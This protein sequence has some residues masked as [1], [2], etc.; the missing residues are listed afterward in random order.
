MIN[1]DLGRSR[2]CMIKIFKNKWETKKDY[3]I[4]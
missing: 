1:T 3:F 2:N 4:K